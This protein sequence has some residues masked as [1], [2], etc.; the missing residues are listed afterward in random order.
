MKAGNQWGQAGNLAILDGRPG[1]LTTT[2]PD[3]LML[4]AM[5]KKIVFISITIF[6]FTTLSSCSRDDT[7]T[8]AEDGT[9]TVSVG[10]VA[11][12]DPS[13]NITVREATKRELESRKKFW[14]KHDEIDTKYPGP[15]IP[16]ITE[17]G[18]SFTV[19]E[20]SEKGVFILTSGLKV[21][22]NGIICA[23]EGTDILNS[24]FDKETEEIS[25]HQES[26]SPDGTILAHLWIIDPSM[27]SVLS[28][29]DT[30]VTNKW[31]EVDYKN[32]SRYHQR[33]VAFSKLDIERFN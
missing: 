4:G 26:T 19:K 18:P 2:H 9:I 8:V 3:S 1:A 15:P 16:S 7:T 28:L 6:L 33:Y 21:K 10:A 14:N 31:C 12:R 13:G 11:Q 32:P 22:M 27:P 20:I 23:T 25:F 24:F 29:N 5:M 30:V 17:P